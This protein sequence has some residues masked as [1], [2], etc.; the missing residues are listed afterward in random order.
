MHKPPHRLALIFFLLTLTT[1]IV[2]ML[3]AGALMM[4]LIQIGLI[5]SRRPLV[6]VLAM[7]IA[8]VLVG[9]VL[10]RFASRAPIAASS[11]SATP[12]RPWPGAISACA[13]ERI[14]ALP[15]CT[16][17]RTISTS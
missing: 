8:S 13:S 9:T 5:E 15:S 7:A 17:W 12:P 16:T 14:P 3:L 6:L 4:L 1:L 10:A 2:T 11:P